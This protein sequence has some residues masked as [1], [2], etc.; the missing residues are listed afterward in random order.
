VRRP[1]RRENSKDVTDCFPTAI[2][3]DE[4]LSFLPRLYGAVISPFEETH[5]GSESNREGVMI[6]PFPRY[7]TAVVEFFRLA[8]KECWSDFRYDPRTAG[9]S[10]ESEESI[11]NASVA[12]IRTLLTYCVR[13]ERFCDGHWGAV[14]QSGKIRLILNRLEQIRTGTP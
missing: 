2:D 14:I 13:G 6:M 5:P 11:A 3:I 9:R 1:I 12:E 8:G 4:L 7:T 10:L